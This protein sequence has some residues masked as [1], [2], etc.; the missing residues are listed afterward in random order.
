MVLDKMRSDRAVGTIL[1]PFT[2][3][4]AWWPLLYPSD[5]PPWP[6]REWYGFGTRY[7]VS[8]EPNTRASRGLT[9]WPSLAFRLDF[10]FG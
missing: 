3:F 8:F 2:L 5:D 6:V 1:V 10:R 4:A 9:P 7:F